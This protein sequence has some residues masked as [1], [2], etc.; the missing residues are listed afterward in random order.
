MLFKVSKEISTVGVQD[1]K[2]QEHS[3]VTVLGSSYSPDPSL[4]HANVHSTLVVFDYFMLK[5]VCR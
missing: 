2:Q 1:F 5:C 4:M 3:C